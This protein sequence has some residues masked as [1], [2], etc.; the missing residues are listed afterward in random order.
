MS[1]SDR[2][3]LNIVLMATGTPILL[4]MRAGIFTRLIDPEADASF[5]E[6]LME[7]IPIWVFFVPLA[8]SVLGTMLIGRAIQTLREIRRCSV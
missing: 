4:A 3:W 2:W 1:R 8:I 6:R 5:V 7:R